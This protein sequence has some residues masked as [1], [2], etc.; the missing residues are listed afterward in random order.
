M[1]GDAIAAIAGMAF[2]LFCIGWFT[3]FP[4]LGLFWLFG[5]LS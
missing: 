4:T 3:L 1:M 2:V 5:W